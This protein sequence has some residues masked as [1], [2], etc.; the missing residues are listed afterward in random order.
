MDFFKAAAQD[1]AKQKFAGGNDDDD[2]EVKQDAVN[3]VQNSGVAPPQDSEIHE[4]KAVH[5]KVYKQGN[6]DDASDDELGKAAGVEAYNAYERSESE[7]GEGGGKGDLM[8]MAMAEAMK[9]FSGGGGKDKSAVLQSAIAMATKMFMSKSGGSG[10]GD[11]GS[12]GLAAIL[13]QAG[14]NPQ[15]ASMLG[16]AAENPQVADLLKKFM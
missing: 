2:H 12:G 3:K 9:M 11:S 8:Q 5:E 10:G 14:S 13:G 16:K 6:T 4:A 1:Y 7:R 15:V